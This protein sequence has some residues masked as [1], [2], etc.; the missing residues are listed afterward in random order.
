MNNT[1]IKPN[2]RL[3]YSS[4]DEQGDHRPLSLLAVVDKVIESSRLHHFANQFAIVTKIE[5]RFVLG[6]EV[7]GPPLVDTI[8]NELELFCV[9]IKAQNCVK[10][11]CGEEIIHLPLKEL[12]LTA[13]NAVRS[14]GGA[15]NNWFLYWSPTMEKNPFFLF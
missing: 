8:Q 5:E 3:F 12:I 9:D 4:L 7:I 6:R 13:D 2:A 11:D 14:L 1:I 10:Y 15:S